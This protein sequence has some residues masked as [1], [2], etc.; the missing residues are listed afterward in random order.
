MCKKIPY[1]CISQPH[2]LGH[3]AFRSELAA[4]TTPDI[5]RTNLA[6]VVLSLKSMG[7]DDLI[8]L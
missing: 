2:H 7:V 1:W 3:R 4:G 6:T 5:Q 8:G